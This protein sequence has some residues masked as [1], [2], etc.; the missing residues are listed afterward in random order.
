MVGNGWRFI[1][2]LFF[3]THFW[4]KLNLTNNCVTI[5]KQCPEL[6]KIGQIRSFLYGARSKIFQY[7]EL[8]LNNTL[9]NNTI[10]CKTLATI[11]S[12]REYVAR[13]F[14]RRKQISTSV[15]I[16]CY[17]SALVLTCFRMTKGRAMYFQP[18]TI[19]ASFF[20]LMVLLFKV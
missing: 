4:N 8:W 13:L 15:E 20:H 11:V 10:K 1:S 5:H 9:N 6:S 16:F 19:V 14:I 17:I 2:S 18:E 7:L 12:G 3:F